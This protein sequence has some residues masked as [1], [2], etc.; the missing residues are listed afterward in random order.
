[1]LMAG[2]LPKEKYN[3]K[4]LKIIFYLIFRVYK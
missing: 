2:K 1:M 3:T 4:Y